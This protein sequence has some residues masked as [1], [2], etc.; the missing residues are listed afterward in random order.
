M[1]MLQA[2]RRIRKRRTPWFAIL[3]GTTLIVLVALFFALVA[4]A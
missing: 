1:E 2:P 3:G 4:L